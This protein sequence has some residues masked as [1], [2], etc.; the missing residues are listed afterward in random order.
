MGG[1]RGFGGEFHRR[2]HFSGSG[3]E[4]D[5]A[6]SHYSVVFRTLFDEIRV[7]LQGAEFVEIG[8]GGGPHRAESAHGP[9][10]RP[11]MK[12]F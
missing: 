4:F 2:F 10:W 3:R 7:G 9:S 8:D 1:N 5:S 12:G 11:E 6:F